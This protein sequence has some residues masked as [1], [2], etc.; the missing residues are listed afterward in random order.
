MSL[1][2]AAEETVVQRALAQGYLTPEALARVQAQRAP[3]SPLLA[4]LATC[5]PAECLPE[6][7]DLYNDV[8][9]GRVAPAPASA[10]APAPAP[11]AR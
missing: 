2:R 6:L 11:A 5:L 10:A 9:Q 4:A 1:D 8:L 7:R 3:G